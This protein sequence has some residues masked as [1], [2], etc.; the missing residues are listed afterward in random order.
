MS[1]VT[2]GEVACEI[3]ESC[4][5]KENM[6]VVALEHL[7]PEEV[8]LT[9]WSTSGD[10]TFSKAFHKGQVLFGRRRAYLKKAA[11]APFDGICSGD[12][13]VIEAKP[14]RLA[15]ELLPFIIQ[16][17]A[18]FDFAVGKSA[19]SL[20]PRVKWEHLKNFEFSLPPLAQQRKLAQVL[21]SMDALKQA[22]RRLM[23]KTDELVKSQFVEMF[24]DVVSNNKHW[25]MKQF[26]T[27]TSSRLGKMLDGKRQT[28]LHKYPY[29][30]NCNVQW[31]HFELN[32]LKEMDFN[33]EEQVEFEL[34]D[35]DLMVCEGGEIGRCAVWHNSIQPCYYQKAI[36]RVRCDFRLVLPD[37]LAWWFK[38]NCEQNSFESIAGAKAT[39]AHLPGEKLKKLMVMLPPVELQHQFVTLISQLDKS[40]FALQKS[41]DELRAL[42]S[43]LVKEH[44]G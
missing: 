34:E 18:F 41:L 21:W 32:D 8:R 38:L 22:Y 3:R 11:L 39:I 35:G 23:D 36:H 24:G 43:K 20:S 4:K 14:D 29:L 17:D 12:I 26:D 31:F 2:L 27:I 44:L 10:N 1:K 13:T 5:E 33:E 25:P 28:G 19:G 6:P 42:S 40:K 16:N 37:Y 30:A 15:P 9:N 7:V